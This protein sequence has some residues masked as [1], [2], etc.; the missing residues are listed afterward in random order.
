MQKGSLNQKVIIREQ[1]K[2]EFRHKIKPGT[3][4]SKHK[5]FLN[6]IG[7]IHRRQPNDTVARAQDPNL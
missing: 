5:F 6:D 4:S 3:Y 1:A 7:L 2:N